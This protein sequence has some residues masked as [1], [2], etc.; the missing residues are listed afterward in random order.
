MYSYTIFTLNS[1]L[2]YSMTFH[3]PHLLPPPRRP[4]QDVPHPRLL[5]IVLS[6]PAESM[7]QVMVLDDE[8]AA[9][10]VEDGAGDGKRPVGANS[11]VTEDLDV[12]A[13]GYWEFGGS[14]E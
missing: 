7:M 6:R 3:P 9:D 4:E 14:G 11:G 8:L 13:E 10:E 12:G 1:M 2:L 5:A